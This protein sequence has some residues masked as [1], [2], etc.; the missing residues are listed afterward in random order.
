[1]APVTKIIAGEIQYDTLLTHDPN[2]L[3]NSEIQQLN[4]DG[5]TMKR[6]RAA[7]MQKLKAE[8]EADC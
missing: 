1:M 6:M 8:S 3:S 7:L 5:I 2:F 4:D